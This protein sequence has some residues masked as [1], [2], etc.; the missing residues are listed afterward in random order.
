MSQDEL[1]LNQLYTLKESSKY[2]GL[3]VKKYKRKVFYDNLWNEEL[4]ESRGRVYDSKGNVVINPFTKIFNYGENGTTI[5]NEECV[6]AVAKINGFMAAATYIP[7]LD[8]VVVSTTGS[9]DSD[10]VTLAERHITNKIKDYIKNFSKY[11]GAHTFLFEICDSSDPH[12]IVEEPGAYLI[13]RRVVSSS[14]PYYSNEFHEYLLDVDSISMGCYRPD[15]FVGTF[16][17][18]K[19][20]IKSSHEKTEGFVIY[21]KNTILKIKTPYYLATKAIARSKDIFKLKRQFIDEEYY[22]LIEHFKGIK[23]FNEFTEEQ[24]LHLIRNYFYG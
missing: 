11:F 3:F 17:E 4:L 18:I 23:G 1:N 22:P 21:G 6:L 20:L 15:Y 24:K 7:N 19:D 2:P 8:K 16:Q 9:L 5:P 10:F 14:K 12:I 13:G